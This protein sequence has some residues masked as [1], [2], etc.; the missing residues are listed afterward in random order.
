MVEEIK[1]IIFSNTTIEQEHPTPEYDNFKF[2]SSCFHNNT[3]NRKLYET[4]RF[5]DLLMFSGGIERDQC[6][7]MV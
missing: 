6:H 2:I 3:K 5:A 4:L 7:E 1:I